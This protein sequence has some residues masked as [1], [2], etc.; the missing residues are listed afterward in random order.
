M[1]GNVPVGGD[2]PITVQTMTNTKTT[3]VAATV[4]QIRRIER[5]GA[6]AVLRFDLFSHA[7]LLCFL[8]PLLFLGFA[9]MAVAINA[10]ALLT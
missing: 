2:A 7:L 1:V 3:D 5:V 6:G 10:W 8:A 4:E 9:Q